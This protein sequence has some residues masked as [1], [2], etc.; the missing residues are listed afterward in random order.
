MYSYIAL[1]LMGVGV[2]LILDQKYHFLSVLLAMEILTLSVIFL[3]ASFLGMGFNLSGINF[4]L[5]FM[6]HVVI[7]VA[8]GLALLVSRTRATGTDKLSNIFSSRF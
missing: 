2:W 5:L 7:E 8:S 3:C 6:V 1:I 4:S